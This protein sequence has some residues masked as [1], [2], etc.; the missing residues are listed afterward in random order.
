MARP[1]TQWTSKYC[2][3]EVDMAINDTPTV[4]RVAGPYDLRSAMK[5]AE[6]LAGFAVNARDDHEVHELDALEWM[7]QIGDVAGVFGAVH[8]DNDDSEPSVIYFV[9]QLMIP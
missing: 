3:V 9:K 6:E 8:V 2:V 4:G 5:T 1:L 7:E